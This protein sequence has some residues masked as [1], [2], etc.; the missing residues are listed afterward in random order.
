LRALDG[1]NTHEVRA[2]SVVPL[3]YVVA[4]LVYVGVGWR[5]TWALG[6]VHGLLMIASL[7][8]IVRDDL[9]RG[10]TTAL[11]DSLSASPRY[12]RGDR[13]A[14]ARAELGGTD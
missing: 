8:L 6:I 3:V 9:K 12:R 4:A 2:L 5:T 14:P 7:V 10:A 13:T 1:G 11:R